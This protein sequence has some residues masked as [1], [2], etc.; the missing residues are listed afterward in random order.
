MKF[1]AFRYY[2]HINFLTLLTTL[3]T[4]HFMTNNRI[5][6]LNLLTIYWH[7]CPVLTI[8][9]EWE[10]T[11]LN[12]PTS[13]QVVEWKMHL[14]S[15]LGTVSKLSSR[16]SGQIVEWKMHLICALKQRSDRSHAKKQARYTHCVCLVLSAKIRHKPLEGSS[17]PRTVDASS[18]KQRSDI[19]HSKVI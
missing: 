19:S 3:Q 10:N 17:T 15:W 16:T 4:I 8:R 18:F 9:Y 5:Q 14:I 1:S 7:P 6:C 11:F 12:L 2:R 13:G